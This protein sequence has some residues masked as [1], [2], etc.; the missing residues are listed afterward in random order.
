MSDKKTRIT[1]FSAEN[2]KRI[3]YAELVFDENDN[4]IM[5]TG[6]QAQGK[7]SFLQ[8]MKVAVEGGRQVTG[9]PVRSGQ[10]KAILEIDIENAPIDGEIDDLHFRRVFGKGAGLTVTRSDKSKSI[11][12]TPMA[13]LDSLRG[14]MVDPLSLF[15]VK[16][17]Q[18]LYELILPTVDLDVDLDELKSKKDELYKER[19][20]V[21]QDVTRLKGHLQ[22]LKD[23]EVLPANLPDGEVSVSELNKKIQKAFDL[24]SRWNDVSGSAEDSQARIDRY[25]EQIRELRQQIED[26]K[27][28]IPDENAQISRDKKELEEFPKIPNIEA[29]N[30]KIETAEETNRLVRHRDNI[31]QTSVEL[32]GVTEKYDGFSRDMDRIDGVGADALLKAKFPVED[33]SFG[34]GIVTLNGQPLYGGASEG[35]FL[36]V[37]VEIAC[38]S[39]HKL[40]FVLVPSGSGLGSKLLKRMAKTAEKHGCMVIVEKLDET[41]EVGVVLEDGQIK[42]DNRE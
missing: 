38:R 29:I 26:I 28:K 13:I 6:D 10:Q 33:M 36:D 14:K 37:C 17:N 5:V 2:Y 24:Q 25:N 31:K 20:R 23:A 32:N 27:A 41:G 4:L 8:A 15:H 11:T 35:E 3:V 21:G 19:T 34:D 12:D 7:T 9:K 22:A 16:N 42:K 39:S 40:P 18:D 30:T 1:R